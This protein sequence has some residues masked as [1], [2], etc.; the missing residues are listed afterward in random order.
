MCAVSSPLLQ[1]GHRSQEHLQDSLD[2]PYEQKWFRNWGNAHTTARYYCVARAHSS[3]FV[4]TTQT[5]AADV[6]FSLS[7][8]QRARFRLASK[9]ELLTVG[10][11]M[12]S[13]Y[14]QLIVASASTMIHRLLVTRTISRPF[15]KNLTKYMIILA[16]LV[17]QVT[18]FQLGSVEV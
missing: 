10:N 12:Q 17:M 4:Y 6:L 11:L 14:A 3:V 8:A 2:T 15:N 13:A 18:V 1:E 7:R 5:R 9:I 16:V